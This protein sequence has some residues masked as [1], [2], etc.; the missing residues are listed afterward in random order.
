[1]TNNGP[2]AYEAVLKEVLDMFAR[3]LA[4][5]VL[6]ALCVTVFGG[7]AWAVYG[8]RI[9]DLN[10]SPTPPNPVRVW[11]RVTSESPLRLSDGRAEV[12]VVGLTASPGD[13]VVITGNW[14]SGVLTVD[15]NVP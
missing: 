10:N 12:T 14:S 8:V 6:A 15:P 3:S 2:E 11:G 1:M 13:F 4:V 7:T 9:S 5:V